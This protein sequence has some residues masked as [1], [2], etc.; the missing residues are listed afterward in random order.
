MRLR[1]FGLGAVLIGLAL[2]GSPVR[3]D[4]IAV[5][6]GTFSQVNSTVGLPD[7]CGTGCSYN[8]AT[9]PGWTSNPG[10]VTGSF[11]PNAS[12]FSSV[13]APDDGIIAY[14]NGGTLS[15]ELVPLAPD[16]TYTLSVDVGDR[17]DGTSG[18]YTISLVDGS[19]VLCSYSGDSDTIA[20]GTFADE[21]CSFSTGATVPSGD[22]TILLSGDGD[23]ATQADFAD[24]TVVT[25]EPTSLALLASG[26]FSLV[27]FG[28]LYRRKYG[29]RNPV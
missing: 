18:D 10:F 25:P 12:Y 28:G 6:N 29:V 9:I 1:I 3:A 4:S 20:P 17:L 7:S 22:L 21:T 24:V 23:A 14:T 16:T 5:T 13:P 8:E 27:L 11:E 19:T 2:L 15:Q 26:L